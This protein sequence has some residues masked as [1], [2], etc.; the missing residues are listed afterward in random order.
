[1][2]DAHVHVWAQDQ[3]R[4]P[5]GP[6]DG[7]V[8]PVGAPTMREFFS[9]AATVGVRGAVLIQPR[10]Y[11]YDHAYLFD[12]ASAREISARNMPDPAGGLM[13]PAVS[14][15]RVVPL[16]NVTRPGNAQELRRLAAHEST[17]AFRVIA[18]E[19]VPAEWL[20]SIEAHRMWEVASQLDL[21]VS[22]LIAPHQLRLANRIARAHADLTIVIDHMGRCTPRLQR[23]FSSALLDLAEWPN[24]YIKLSAIGTL[25]NSP[26]PYPDMHDLLQSLYLDYGA[27]RLLW[28]SDW[29][30]VGRPGT[31]GNASAAVRQ[32]LAS[33][34]EEDLEMIFD[35]TAARLFGFDSSSAGGSDGN[36]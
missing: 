28:G 8:A 10:F 11:G 15:V 17:A 18:L 20:C 33:A 4:Y 13:S 36:T 24:V 27:S 25:S 21:P 3:L 19:E 2:I 29:P 6:H 22:L 32:A 7:L 5:F 14:R 1:M 34:A 9:N 16:V 31:Y 12:T 23:Q 26:F 35:A 30:H